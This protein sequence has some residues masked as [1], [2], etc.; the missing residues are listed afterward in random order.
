ML[1]RW[2]CPHS[3]RDDTHTHTP[4]A[5]AVFQG[6][7][8]TDS[9]G[10]FASVRSQPAWPG[11]GSSVFGPDS[12]GVRL[13]VRGD[14]R[15]YKL[16]IQD[17]RAEVNY[18]ADFAPSGSWQE[19]CQQFLNGR[20]KPSLPSPIRLRCRFLISRPQC[21]GATC[22]MRHCCGASVCVRLALWCQSSTT[23][24]GSTP[25]SFPAAFA[26]MC[27]GSGHWCEHPATKDLATG[28]FAPCLK[29]GCVLP[30]RNDE[31]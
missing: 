8:S 16:T 7:V 20:S 18:Q 14:G 24:G 2:G 4:Q 3:P 19:V 15:Q 13:H 27:D 29:G 6:H 12:N 22:L 23:R 21:V 31:N 17:E 25:C 5:C 26:S 11:W 28:V 1:S 10:G 9:N 30:R